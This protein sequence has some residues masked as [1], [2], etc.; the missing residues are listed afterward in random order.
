MRVE[1]I[2]DATLYLGDC[3]EILPTLPSADALITDPP[4]GTGGWRRAE[5]GKGSNPAAKLVKEAWD[6][7]ANDWLALALCPVLTFW[8][9][10]HMP[11]LMEAARHAGYCKFRM[12]Y[13]RK[14]DPKP[15]MAGAFRG[16][17]SR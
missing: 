16:P 15:Q 3:R 11:Q 6:D 13:M 4:Y 1:R 10:A 14:L 7:G 2:G 5:S 9:S 12:L 8:P 17:S